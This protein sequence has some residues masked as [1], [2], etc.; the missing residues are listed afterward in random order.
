MTN[1]NNSIK[2]FTCKKWIAKLI[3]RLVAKGLPKG[4][5]IVLYGRGKGSSAVNFGAKPLRYCSR[6][7]IYVYFYDQEREK[8]S[9]DLSE[10]RIKERELT[11]ELELERFKR[12]QI[13]GELDAYKRIDD[14]SKL[15]VN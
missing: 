8:Y 13:E 14:A 3:K 6:A 1:Y 12:E 10:A 2:L 4:V 5:K 15:G 11:Q 7:V 9:K